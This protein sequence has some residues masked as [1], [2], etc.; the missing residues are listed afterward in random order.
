MSGSVGPC[1]G[2]PAVVVAASIGGSRVVKNW[3]H[4]VLSGK[5]GRFPGGRLR[6]DYGLA[7]RML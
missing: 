1:G 7:R 3:K 4:T 6:A 5:H 2:G